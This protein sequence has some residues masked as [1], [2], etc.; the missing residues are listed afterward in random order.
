MIIGI[1]GNSVFKKSIVEDFRWART[2]VINKRLNKTYVLS[3]SRASKRLSAAIENNT[4][5]D[6]SI[7]PLKILM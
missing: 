3:K 7:D 1:V 6:K 2:W 5:K 4:Y